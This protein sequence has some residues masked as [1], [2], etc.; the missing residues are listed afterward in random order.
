MMKLGAALGQ[1]MYWLMRCRRSIAATNIQ[2]AFPQLSETERHSLLTEHFHNVGRTIVESALSWWGKKER[3]EK[4]A[5]I[6]NLE[7]L[8]E[9]AAEGKGWFY[10]VLTSLALRLVCAC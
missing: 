8:T 1:L 6:H 7:Y 4:L 5:H 3:L 2:M 10:S 9:A